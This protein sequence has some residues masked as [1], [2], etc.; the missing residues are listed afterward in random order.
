MNIKALA[1]ASIIG[2]SAPAIIE[3]AFTSQGA[4][5]MPTDFVRATGTF[6]DANQEWVVR[7]YIDRNLHL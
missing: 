4:S 7:L 2:F 3:A 5:A 6:V 1:L